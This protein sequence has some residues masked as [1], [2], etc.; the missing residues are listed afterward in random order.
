M[1]SI[2][3][4]DKIG[5]SRNLI[6][7]VLAIVIPGIG[8]VYLGAFRRGIGILVAGIGLLLVSYPGFLGIN[9]VLTSNMTQGMSMT[10]IM[11]LALMMVGLGAIGFWIWQIL[12]AKKIAKQQ[13]IEG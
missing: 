13:S 3:I 12:D 7:T 8:H 2:G 9:S 11:V 10:S 5:L 4:S 6:A 1:L